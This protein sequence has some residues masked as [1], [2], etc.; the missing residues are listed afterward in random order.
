M[1][2]YIC[3]LAQLPVLQYILMY[4]FYVFTLFIIVFNDIR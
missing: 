1:L 4:L 3:D 2:H